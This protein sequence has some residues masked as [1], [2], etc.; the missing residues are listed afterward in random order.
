[1][2]S[3][4]F[5]RTSAVGGTRALSKFSWLC[6]GNGISDAKRQLTEEYNE[7]IALTGD[8][9]VFPS[10]LWKGMPGEN[11]LRRF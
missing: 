8:D 3:R 5:L 4:C 2:I 7:A 6:K 11:N 9:F 1:M 10:C